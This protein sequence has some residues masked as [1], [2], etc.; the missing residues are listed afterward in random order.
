MQGW[1]SPKFGEVGCLGATLFVLVMVGSIAGMLYM[2]YS[3]V[4]NP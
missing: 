4:L 3:H 1:M 2:L